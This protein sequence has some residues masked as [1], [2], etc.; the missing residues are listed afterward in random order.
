MAVF[1]L[2]DVPENFPVYSSNIIG[3][4]KLV[5]GTNSNSNDTL[6][7]MLNKFVKVLKLKHFQMFIF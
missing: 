4:I 5:Y 2:F 7:S 3:E 1:I 6:N